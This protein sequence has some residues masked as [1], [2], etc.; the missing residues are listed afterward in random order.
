VDRGSLHRFGDQGHPKPGSEEAEEAEMMQ[1][2]GLHYCSDL[3]KQVFAERSL[4]IAANRAPVNL[5]T[6][7]DGNFSFERG[8]GGLVTALTGLAS[9]VQ[10]TWIGCAMNPADSEWEEGDVPIEGTDANIHVRFLSPDPVVYQRYYSEIANPLLWFLQH[11]M[12]DVPRAP[13]IDRA[14][15]EAWSDGYVSVNRQFA[16]AVVK[17]TVGADQPPLIMLQD[18]HLYLVPRF[19]RQSFSRRD[20]PTIMH[21]IHIPWPGPEYWKILPPSMRNAIFDGLCAADLLGFQTVDD[22]LNFLRTCET[23]LPRAFVK[24]KSGRI[25]YRNHATHV[26]DFPISID[27]QALE[28]TAASPEVKRYQ[29]DISDLVGNKQLILRIDRIE[30]SKNILRGF[31]AFEEMLEHYPAHRGR[32]IFLAI[33]VPS[34]MGVEEYQ[35]YL[36]EIGAAAGR[37]NADLGDSDWE[38]VRLLVGENY[39]RA[40]AALHFYDVLLVNSIADGMNLVAKEGP[41]VNQQDGIL[42]LS[43]RAGA[44]QQLGESALVISP[45]DVFAT[46]EAMHQALIMPADERKRRGDQ[47]KRSV[48]K[49]DIT[50]WLCRQLESL[51]ELDL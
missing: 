8:S 40:V 37:I 39:P 3:Q 13:M 28:E 6:D 17:E 10:A 47:L 18:Y 5:L 4:I 35:D 45:C 14:T 44:Q 26:R 34:R 7:E 11:S 27:V 50:A 42:I 9:Q 12:W 22:S 41:I 46:S 24:Y 30:P 51:I 25:W 29:N 15:W 36:D 32:V 43:E 21:F 49:D 31:T 20:R 38:P 23:F 2:K 33:L 16:E 48:E 1:A 19:I